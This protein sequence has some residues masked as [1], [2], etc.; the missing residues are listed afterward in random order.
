MLFL[1]TL[2]IVWLAGVSDGLAVPSLSI[3]LMARFCVWNRE[4]I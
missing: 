4:R 3:V 1:S 2:F